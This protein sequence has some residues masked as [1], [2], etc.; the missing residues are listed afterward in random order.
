MLEAYWPATQLLHGMMPLDENLPAGQG[1][2]DVGARV[3]RAVGSCVG[4]VDPPEQEGLHGD[5][6]YPQKEQHEAQFVTSVPPEWHWSLR[7][8]KGAPSSLVAASIDQG[9]NLCPRR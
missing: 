7:R 2:G 9:D 8:R 4:A 3:C 5:S 6:Q 1:P